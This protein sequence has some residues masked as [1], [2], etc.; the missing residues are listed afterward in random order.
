MDL[1]PALIIYLGVLLFA[2]FVFMYLEYTVFA[3]TLLAFVVAL[4]Y[5]N[6]AYPVTKKELDE[7]NSLTVLYIF[8]Q[9]FTLALVF[10]YAVIATIG[11]KRNK[12][13]FPLTLK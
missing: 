9:M 3:A 5:L 8:I 6:I 11:K 4:I 1:G 13:K 2:F 12:T 10:I 7:V